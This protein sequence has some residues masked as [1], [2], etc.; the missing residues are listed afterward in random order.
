MSESNVATTAQEP[1]D[2]RILVSKNDSHG[3]CH[4]WPN[5]LLLYTEGAHGEEYNHA[6]PERALERAARVSDGIRRTTEAL[7]EELQKPE[8]QA[9]VTVLRAAY[10]RVRERSGT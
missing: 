7:R 2:D 5:G 4:V 8:V 10:A 3:Q 9:A 6:T 1:F